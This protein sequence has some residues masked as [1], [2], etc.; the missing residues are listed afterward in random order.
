M[1]TNWANVFNLK[2]YAYKNHQKLLWLVVI[3]EIC[4]ISSS[5]LNRNIFC[6]GKD[7]K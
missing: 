7:T 3:D 6:E 5:K 1:M 2:Y 4:P